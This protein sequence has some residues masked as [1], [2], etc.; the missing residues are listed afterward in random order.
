MRIFNLNIRASLSSVELRRALRGLWAL[1]LLSSALA[2]AGCK[3]SGAYEQSVYS[4]RLVRFSV[5]PPEEGFE[6]IRIDGESG[7]AWANDEGAVI[8]VHARCDRALDIPL[9]ALKAHL[10]IG[11]TEREE[12]EERLL[13]MDSREALETH[14]RAKVDGVTRELILRILKKD[15]C[16]YDLAL[17]AG[18]GAPFNRARPHFER[19]AASFT[20][21][22]PR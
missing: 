5:D 9:A 13:P 21:E 18:P 17:I 20:T 1:A 10:L 6:R 8:Q 12:I 15:G 7:L 22:I 2:F 4:D 16:V 11:F 19:V 14:L 3:S